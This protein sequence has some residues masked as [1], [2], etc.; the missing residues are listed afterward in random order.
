MATLKTSPNDQSVEAYLDGIDNEQKR[1]DSKKIVELMQAV[2]GQPPVMWGD[3]IVGF[4]SYHYK[5]ASGREGDWFLTGFA[6]RQQ[7]LTLYI[8]AGFDQYDRLM[9]QLGKYK[10]GKSCLYIKKLADIDE[11]VLKTL[12]EESIAYLKKQ[13]GEN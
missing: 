6:A 5:Y 13:Y 3:G 11:D 10:I 12:I 8:M 7:S 9:E 4:G 2:S 1:A